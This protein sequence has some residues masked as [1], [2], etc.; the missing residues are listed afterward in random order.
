MQ[1]LG[2]ISLQAAARLIQLMDHN[3]L[4][5]KEWIFDKLKAVRLTEVANPPG[6]AALVGR[7][8]GSGLRSAA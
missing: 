6:N 5:L 1:V 3:D 7:S 8:I 2:A 4:D